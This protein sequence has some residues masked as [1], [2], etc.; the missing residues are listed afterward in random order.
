MHNSV[1]TVIVYI[2]NI[3]LY[4]KCVG[5]LYYCINSITGISQTSVWIAKA[6]IVLCASALPWESAWCPLGRSD[7]SH[8]YSGFQ[9]SAILAHNLTQSLTCLHAANCKKKKK[10]CHLERH[11]TWHLH[12]PKLGILSPLPQSMMHRVTCTYYPQW[13]PNFIAWSMHARIASH[14]CTIK[15]NIAPLFF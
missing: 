7:N 8:Q 15:L 12:I 14:T 6:T 10:H 2:L 9:A 4:I 1:L 13:F 11:D 3:K 5:L